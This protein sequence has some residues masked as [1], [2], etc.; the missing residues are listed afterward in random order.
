MTTS[1]ASEHP[2]PRSE[3]SPLTRQPVAATGHPAPRRG[4]VLTFR[5]VAALAGAFFLFA[6]V[7]NAAAPWTLLLPGDDRHADLNR[8][9][10]A[11]SGAADLILACCLLAL[12]YRP[13]LTL[14]V[15]DAVLAV[16][17]AAVILLPLQPAFAF[18]LPIV[19]LPLIAYPYWR[20]VRD[21]SRW[22]TGVN[23]VLL[24]LTSLVAAV[25]VVTAVM[26]YSRQIGGTDP[27]AQANWWSDYA[28]HATLIGV[29][30]VLASSRGPGHRVLAALCSV[31]WLYLGVVAA[32]VLPNYTGSWGR[33]GGAVA[34]AVGVGFAVIAARGT[35]RV[36]VLPSPRPA[37]P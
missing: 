18:Y 30:G 9:F 5:V 23:P 12:V 1:D 24:A 2:T 17:I 13:K 33:I 8:W 32:L 11:V 25:L 35:G 14:L 3:P 10:F 19:V 26:A 37:A 20:D 4:R 21:V 34:I 15:V 36:V 29:A 7:S 16:M 27:A 22:W 6:A 28:E 31:A